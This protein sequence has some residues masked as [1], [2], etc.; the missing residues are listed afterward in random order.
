MPI[1]YMGS[2]RKSAQLIFNTIK[3]F[4]PKSNEIADLFC[5]G[6]AISEIFIRNGWNVISN[7]AEPYIVALINQ[8][9]K[10][11]DEKKV[12]EWVSRSLYEDIK[13]NPT[14]YDAW[15]V[16][17]VMTIWA[18]GNTPFGSYLF[19]REVEP[20]KKAGHDLVIHKDK[21]EVVGLIP[22]KY[23][24]GILKQET[25]GKRRMALVKVA[26]VLKNREYEL[27]QLQQLQRLQRLERLQR[28]NVSN[29]SYE[30]VK[31]PKG[32]IIYCDPPYASTAEYKKNGFNHQLFWDW[33]RKKSKTNKVY[34]S[35]YRAPNDFIKVLE[36]SQKSTL[37][38]KGP[39]H[40]SPNECLFAMKGQ[41]KFTKTQ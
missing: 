30:E 37:S 25:W 3:N 1:P 10:G 4:N 33:V 39:K 8:T 14:K 38:A 40:D 22:N 7:D 11:L 21:T 36:F 16:G 32:V 9:L 13:S 20:T 18:F 23:I 2:K 35:E 27:Q 28:L 12:T 15:Y 6:F 24:K 17:Y 41:E 26:R 29:L 34:V 31:I 5:G 19:G